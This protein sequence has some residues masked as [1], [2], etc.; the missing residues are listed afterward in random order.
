L[1]EAIHVQ[2]A[3]ESRGTQV[4]REIQKFSRQLC[5]QNVRLNVRLG[6]MPKW[7]DKWQDYPPKIVNHPKTALAP[8]QI[9]ANQQSGQYLDLRIREAIFSC[10]IQ[11][12]SDVQ[13]TVTMK[14]VKECG[15]FIVKKYRNV[16]RR[17]ERAIR[18]K[19]G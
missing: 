3:K 11:S 12:Q 9:P 15:S 10:I 18:G 4:G 17:V 1:A 16:I 7:R 5:G 6:I 8:N 19:R 13:I 2:R 14:T